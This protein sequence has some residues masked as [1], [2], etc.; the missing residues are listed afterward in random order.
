MATGPQPFP[1]AIS[2]PE[3]PP[4][5]MVAPAEKSNRPVCILIDTPKESSRTYAK[6]RKN[7]CQVPIPVKSAVPATRQ[8]IAI[9]TPDRT[10]RSRTPPAFFSFFL[11]VPA[12]VSIPDALLYFR[13]YFS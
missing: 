7:S 4:M 1:Y 13:L 9:I 5:S 10:G 8:A 11:T 6:P 12:F 3:T 2:A